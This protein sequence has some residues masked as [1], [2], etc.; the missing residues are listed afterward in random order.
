MYRKRRGNSFT[1]EHYRNLCFLAVA[2]QLHLSRAKYTHARTRAENLTVLELNQGRCS[3]KNIRQKLPRDTLWGYKAVQRIQQSCTRALSSR[4]SSR[5]QISSSHGL[6]EYLGF[7]RATQKE[8]NGSAGL[9]AVVPFGGEIMH[10]TLGLELSM[11]IAII[12]TAETKKK[13][14]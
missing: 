4:P 5:H 7:R 9:G 12:H 1:P 6:T 11:H 3:L 13:K 10:E 8:S 2:I 14:T